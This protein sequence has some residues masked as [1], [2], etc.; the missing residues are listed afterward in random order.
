M[1]PWRAKFL[2]RRTIL[3]GQVSVGLVHMGRWLVQTSM[4]LKSPL[5]DCWDP[6]RGRDRTI[7]GWVFAPKKKKDVPSRTLWLSP[8]Q[9]VWPTSGGTFPFDGPGR[10]L[11]AIDVILRVWQFDGAT[12]MCGRVWRPKE[13]Q[14]LSFCVAFALKRGQRLP[15]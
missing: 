14:R 2:M 15:Q 3:D 10:H 7:L 8:T 5:D 11:G 9:G 6:I 1:S 13:G 12:G 4:G